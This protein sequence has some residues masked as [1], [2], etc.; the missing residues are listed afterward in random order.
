MQ[1][2]L[3]SDVAIAFVYYN[4]QQTEQQK[5]PAIVCAL[6]KQLCRKKAVVPPGFLKTKQDA[7]PPSELADLAIF[8]TL[9]QEFKELFILVDALD[10]CLHERRHEAIGFFRALMSALPCAKV[11]V[12]S[13]KEIDI[14]AAFRSDITPT[15]QVGA[16]NTSQDI[17]NYVHAETKRLRAGDHGK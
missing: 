17:A 2:A 16:K 3:D 10:E 14:E 6:I 8:V 1:R 13:R 15:V 9:A 4:Y 12:T 5:L 7:L 11:F